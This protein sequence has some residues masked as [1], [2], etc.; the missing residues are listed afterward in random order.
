LGPVQ[1]NNFSND[2]DSG[3]GCIL[4]K[5]VDD[6]KLSGVVDMIEGRD[7]DQRDLHRLTKW[8]HVNLLKFNM[9]KCKVLHMGEGNSPISIQTGG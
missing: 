3:T 9:D 8:A 6:T 5:F 4:S 2:I 7:A 1:F